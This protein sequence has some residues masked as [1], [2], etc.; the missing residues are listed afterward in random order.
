[1]S[2]SKNVRLL[3]IAMKLDLTVNTVSRALRDKSDIG[4]ETKLLVKKTA[5]EMGYI[6]NS[7]ASS[8]RNGSSRT[9]AIIFDNLMNPY[10][11]IMADKIH[12][13]LEPLG[14]ATMIFAGTDGKFEMD[15]LAPIVSR[16]VDG[17]LTFLEPTLEV[18]NQIEANRIPIVLIGRKNTKL[19]LDS[20][21]TDDFK[22][23]YEIGR[24]FISK[25]RHHIGYIGAPQAVENS[26]RR[27]NGLKASMT[28]AQIEYQKEN[29]R[30]METN[31]IKDDLD[32]L[33]NN[34]VNAV[35]CFNDMLAL[36][37]Y[38]ILFNRGIRVPEDIMIAGFDHLQSDILWPI[39][40]TSIASDK[41]Q[42]IDTSVKL[43]LSRIE[44]DQKNYKTSYIDY[45]VEL[46]L[47]ETT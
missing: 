35:F 44:S 21:S 16:K 20:V 2:P 37:A 33:I 34:H 6:P 27:L 23:G 26:K 12:K 28:E 45:D 43:L 1:M 15:S 32:V 7:I 5:D 11:M 30:F 42:I 39:K 36:E 40:L 8:L 29:F 31:S 17:I 22:G 13:K 9:I 10:F 14:Y 19:P 3:D 25:Q 18:M 4:A 46:V 24:L 47:G 38:S 41:E